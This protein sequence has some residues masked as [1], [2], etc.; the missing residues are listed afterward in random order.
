MAKNKEEKSKIIENLK[1]QVN[2]KKALIF[3][4][5]QGLKVE[6]T[7][8]LRN[9]LR[10]KDISFN[11]TKNSLLKKVLDEAGISLNDQ[12]YT[13]PLA[14][15]FAKDDEVIVSKEIYNFIKEHEALQVLGGVIDKDFVEASIIER[16]SKLP[17]REELLA[18]AVGSIASPLSGMVNVLAGNI[19]GLINVLAQYKETK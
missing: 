14:L 16:L 8:S 18:K 7:E 17:S 1:D 15:A 4:D 19:R 5:Y 12:V 2:N 6:E 13:K 11:I 9:S 3:I 10:E